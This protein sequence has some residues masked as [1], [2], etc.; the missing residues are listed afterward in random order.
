MTKFG[1]NLRK[2]RELQGYSQQ[3]FAKK[4]G[5]SQKTVSKYET[6]N[7]IPTYPKRAKVAEVLGIDLD[8]LMGEVEWVVR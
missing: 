1:K 5:V 8:I 2:H 3:Q 7:T 4:L 6:L